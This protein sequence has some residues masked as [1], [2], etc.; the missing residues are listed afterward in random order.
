[1]ADIKK[2]EKDIKTIKKLDKSKVFTQKLKNNMID[3][4]N[5]VNYNSKTS[6]NEENS[7]VEYGSNKLSEETNIIFRKSVNKFNDYGQRAT[8]E[9]AENI[10]KTKQKIKSIKKKIQDN[11]DIKKSTKNIKSK[12]KNTI[13]SGSNATRRTLKNAPKTTEV[14]LKRTKKAEKEAVK[15]A[16]KAY[17]IAKETAKRTAKT[18]KLAIKATIKAIKAII[19]ATRMLIAFLI[20]GGWIVVMIIIVIS[21]IALLVSSVFGIFF[22]SEDTGSTITV[23]D[24]EQSVTMSK[25]I[26]DL[27]VEFMNKITQIQQEN[28]YDEYDI[29]GSR[30]EWKDI[31]AVY[32]AKVSNGNNQVEMMT[33]NDEKVNTLKEIFWAMN[34]VAFTKD[35][36]TKQ[37]TIIH[38]T[39]TEHKTVTHTKLHIT[40]NSKSANEM[41]DNYSFNQEQRN[42]LAEFQ[43][44][45]YASMWSAVIYGSSVGS[46]D[47]VEVARQQIGNVGGQPYWSWYGFESRVEW[48]ACFVSWCANQCGYIEAGIIPKFAG[49]EAEGVA[50]FKTCGLWKDRGYIPKARRYYIF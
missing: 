34:E 49:C 2:K 5:K 37:E 11:K 3:V 42:Q 8:K 31:L 16:K 43:K 21:L 9:T 13:K 44:E 40:I 35:V 36:E 39:W 23:N 47:I 46:N 10:Q 25:V 15:G 12:A 45:E 24:I 29:S 20:A 38:L 32:V 19:T 28:P 14:I 27:N 6:D 48:C 30:A 17:Q 18:V 50:W 22:S 4:K 1:M 41:A 26:S 33:L 7:A